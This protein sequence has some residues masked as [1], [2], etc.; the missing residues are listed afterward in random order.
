MDPVER[1]GSMTRILPRATGVTR[2]VPAR[3][4]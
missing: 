2:R 1:L 4:P 3:L